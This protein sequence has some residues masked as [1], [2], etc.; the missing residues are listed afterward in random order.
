M[1]KEITL[2][3][4]DKLAMYR[5]AFYTAMGHQAT[6]E[7]PTDHQCIQWLQCV[8]NQALHVVDPPI[9]LQARAPVVVDTGKKLNALTNLK[10]EVRQ[11][12]AFYAM[13]N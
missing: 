3:A 4:K 10:I 6:E 13:P 2:T 8:L 7:L 11:F 5:N 1:R 12:D 9:V